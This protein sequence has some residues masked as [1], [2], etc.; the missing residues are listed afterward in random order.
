MTWEELKK[1]LPTCL[2]QTKSNLELATKIKQLEKQ[3][4]LYK[5]AIERT[6]RIEKCLNQE[7][8]IKRLQE[9]LLIATNA[10]EEYT[11]DKWN[12][13]DEYYNY[14]LG[15]GGWCHAE[16]ALKEI[17]LVEASEKEVK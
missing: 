9:Q 2:T 3:L 13:E 7:G 12:F 10:L 17:K 16:E 1:Y 14:P 15:S 4:D 6:D 11:I 5:S 8:Q